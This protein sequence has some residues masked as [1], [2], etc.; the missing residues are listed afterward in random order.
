[1]VLESLGQEIID[2]IKDSITKSM[3][4]E[5]N[6]KSEKYGHGGS[7]LG[8]IRFGNQSLL[9]GAMGDAESFTGGKG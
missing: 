4:F 1:M 9:Q 7:V 8:N 5:R 6:V 2:L 3:V